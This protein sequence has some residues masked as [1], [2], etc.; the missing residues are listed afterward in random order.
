MTER[1]CRVSNGSKPSGRC[2]RQAGSFWLFPFVPR[3]IPI[4]PRI[5]SQPEIHVH[6]R[7]KVSPKNQKSPACWH[8]SYKSL[9]PGVKAVHG[10]HRR[11]LEPTFRNSQAFARRSTAGAVPELCRRGRFSAQDVQRVHFREGSRHTAF[12]GYDLRRDSR[13]TA[14]GLLKRRRLLGKERRLLGSVFV[15]LAASLIAPKAQTFPRGTGGS[16]RH[17]VWGNV[18]APRRDRVGDPGN[19]RGVVPRLGES[20]RATAPT[21]PNSTAQAGGLGDRFPGTR[22][23]AQRAVTR[24]AKG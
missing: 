8:L 6:L 13:H 3:P 18:A 1:S 2:L 24:G 11:L 19:G 22:S 21:G 7:M 9:L 5:D 15:P 12:A 10:I 23:K 17:C 14:C 16:G 20:D 4:E